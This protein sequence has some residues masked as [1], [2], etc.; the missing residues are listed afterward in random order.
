MTVMVRAT[1]SWSRS[2]RATTPA[3]SRSLGVSS[4]RPT[5][6]RAKVCSLPSDLARRSDVHLA[7]VLAL[8]VRDERG[9]QRGPTWAEAWPHPRARGRARNPGPGAAAWPPWPAPPPTGR[10]PASGP[11][12]PPRAR[13][14]T[15]TTPAP[16]TRRPS[17]MVGLDCL[18]AILAKSLLR[19]SPTP[20]RS[21]SSSV[22]RARSAAR[23]GHR[24]HA[25]ATQAAQ[26]GEDL[27][28]AERLVLRGQVL[29]Q[30]VEAPRVLLVAIEA[31]GQHDQVR[32]EPL[33]E[34]ARHR[35]AHAV[36]AGLVAGRGDDAAVAGAAH[37]DGLAVSVGSS[38]IS[39][40][41]K[42]AS[43]STCRIGASS[44]EGSSEGELDAAEGLTEVHAHRPAGLL[45][46]LVDDA[47]GWPRRPRPSARRGRG[48]PH[49]G[50]DGRGDVGHDV[51]LVGAAEQQVATWWAA[52]RSGK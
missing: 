16:S 41:A 45:G 33:G 38:R 25:E 6:E 48:P 30:G 35:A 21:E 39:T 49:L 27:V 13:G 9:R 23:G 50:V 2:V 26:V 18:E 42:K 11:A 34:D 10:R 52:P 44:I 5:S 46:P 4:P 29:D 51:G 22:M 15:H 20:Q 3:C 8:G 19:P 36:A 43:R 28:E 7:A 32:A 47:L 40:E 17:S 24:A 14:E 12:T 1:R 37:G 31:A